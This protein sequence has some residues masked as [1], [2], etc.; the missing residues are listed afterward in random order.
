MGKLYER[1]VDSLHLGFNH[2]VDHSKRPI[3]GSRVRAPYSCPSR[4]I[5]RATTALDRCKDFGLFEKHGLNLD[6]LEIRGGSLLMQALIGQSVNSA[7]VG[8]QAAI[9]ALLSGANVA[10]TGG[11]STRRSTSL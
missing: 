1:Y 3:N 4:G 2:S 10:I 5:Q 6:L 7:D 11:L 9:R 8:A